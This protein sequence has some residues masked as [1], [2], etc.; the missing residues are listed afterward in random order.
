MPILRAEKKSAGAEKR[1]LLSGAWG[2]AKWLA[3]S[4]L[5][6][7]PR[8][9]IA[10][11]ARLIQSLG[12]AVFG[13]HRVNGGIRTLADR[14]FDLAATAFHHGISIEELENL[15]F[16]RQC[17]TARTAYLSFGLGWLFF[18]AWLIRSATMPWAAGHIL[19]VLEFAPFC[20]IFFL[21]AFRAALKNYQIRTRRLATAGE[22]LRTERS[23]WPK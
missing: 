13:G 2:G 11:N 12:G 16:R 8:D 5:Q 3:A 21:T 7:I 6:S 9:Q 20:L 10:Q 1:S 23:F 14:T 15:L 19:P 4:P 22:Y 18:V 17:E